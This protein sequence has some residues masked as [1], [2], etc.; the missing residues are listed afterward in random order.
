MATASCENAWSV[1]I[2]TRDAAARAA[3]IHHF[4]YLVRK[5]V[6][7]LALNMPPTLDRDDLISAGS[8]GLIKA[9]D[10]FNPELGVKFETY[11]ISLIRGAVLE[12]LREQDLVPRGIRSAVKSIDR[13]MANLEARLGR[14]ASEHEIAAELNLDL[15]EYFQL[16]SKTS[17]TLVVSLDEPLMDSNDGEGIYLLEALADVEANTEEHAMS[18]ERTRHLSEALRKLPPREFWVLALYYREGCTYREVGRL[19]QVSESRA[20]QLKQQAVIRLGTYLKEY[21]TLFTS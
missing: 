11:A 1:F 8:I 18:H 4:G 14:P 3:L 12:S 15:D 17:R 13:A 19:L 5:T 7:R 21:A 20:F 2:T 6:G 16:L 10:N 9:V